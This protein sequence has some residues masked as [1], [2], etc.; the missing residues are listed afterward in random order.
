MTGLLQDHSR[1]SIVSLLA[2]S[3]VG[4]LP[5]TSIREKTG[6]TAGNLSSHLRTLENAGLVHTTKQFQGR[7]P[8]T[9]IELTP[10][11][12]T[13]LDQAISAME[14]FVRAHRNQ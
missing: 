9:T 3:S 14:E 1:L 7:R 12:R 10:A 5:F 4:E 11:G 13:A 8:L 2:S 6:L